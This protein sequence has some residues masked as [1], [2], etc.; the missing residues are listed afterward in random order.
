ME[1]SGQPPDYSTINKTEDGKYQATYSEF[2]VG[3][4]DS[5]Y[6]L[7]VSGYSGNAGDALSYH[8]GHKFTTQDKDQDIL[9]SENCAVIYQGG[10]WYSGCYQVNVNGRWQAGDATG[11]NWNSISYG[12]SKDLTFVEMKLR[13][14]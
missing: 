8:S 10:F 11:V 2:S 6:V 14:L 12:N 3:D 1:F 7:Y 9:S 5:G 13:I 4:A